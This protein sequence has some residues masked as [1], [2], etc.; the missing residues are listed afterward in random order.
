MTPENRA[1]QT[2]VRKSFDP[3]SWIFKS[4]WRLIGCGT[5]TVLTLM[6]LIPLAVTM[7]RWGL[8]KWDERG[9]F[10]DTFGVVNALFSGLGF[11]GVIA[12]L[13]LQHRELKASHAV[14]LTQIE[15]RAAPLLVADVLTKTIAL[16]RDAQGCFTAACDLGITNYG[17]DPAVH[18]EVFVRLSR[19]SGS[20]PPEA[21]EDLSV[22]IP[23]RTVFAPETE[24]RPQE[25]KHLRIKWDSVPML[26]GFLA[27]VEPDRRFSLEVELRFESAFGGKFLAKQQFALEPRTPS[28]A[29]MSADQQGDA[30]AQ[31]EAPPTVA[32]PAT[33]PPDAVVA[34]L[35]A[36][37]VEGQEAD[38]FLSCTPVDSSFT[39]KKQD[40]ETR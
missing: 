1:E 21:S 20:C 33:P 7:E 12:A 2:A 23:P 34:W 31:P 18:G 36:G 40:V 11:V 10:G 38:A 3:I 26:D 17:P 29:S 30:T 4:V 16:H 6:V 35:H 15:C 8:S 19:R 25:R 27:H 13:Y 37:R 24:S 22:A 9:Q 5:A 14:I 28:T 32:Q 39:F